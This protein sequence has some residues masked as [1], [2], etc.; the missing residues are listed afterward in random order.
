LNSINF[1]AAVSAYDRGDY[2]EALKGFYACIKEDAA[3]FLPGE[4]GLVYYRLGNCLLKTR[5][6]A[7]AATTYE[8]A[9]KDSDYRDKSSVQVNLGKA[10]TATGDYQRAVE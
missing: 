6:F 3:G 4:L 9:L 10:L 1:E 8:K 5:N 7:E 2:V